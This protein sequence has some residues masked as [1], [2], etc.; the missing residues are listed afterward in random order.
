MG[1]RPKVLALACS[2]RTGGNSEILLDRLIAGASDAGAAV[3]KIHVPR[4]EI[5]GCI[6]CNGCFGCGFC[7]VEDDFQYVAKK[8]TDAD[9][10][11]IATPVFFMGPSAQAKAMIDRCQSFWARKYVLKAP[12]KEEPLEMER[13]GAWVSVGGTRGTRLFDGIE[14]TMRY[15]FDAIYIASYTRVEARRV[16]AKGEILRREDA[17]S[18]AYE[19][20]IELAQP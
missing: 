1:R 20:G 18:D 15:F 6:E 14:L 3:E 12:L 9:R 16:D 10:V 17:L 5:A 8:L 4:L 19:K 7:V 2:P 13:R 11:V